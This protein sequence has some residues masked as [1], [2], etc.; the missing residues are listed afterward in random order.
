MRPNSTIT[1]DTKLIQ[2]NRTE[3]KGCVNTAVAI[4]AHDPRQNCRF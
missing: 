4:P 1:S 3:Q 2:N